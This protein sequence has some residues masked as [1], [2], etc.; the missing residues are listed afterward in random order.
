MATSNLIKYDVPTS[1][2]D[3]SNFPSQYI[4]RITFYRQLNTVVCVYAFVTKTF[5]N[6]ADH[7]IISQDKIPVDFRPTDNDLYRNIISY[8]GTVRHGLIRIN[9]NGSM[10]V[11]MG[12]ANTSMNVYGSIEYIVED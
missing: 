6:T 9:T 10:Q 8:M 2:M 12:T 1:E 4:P 11:R 5:S 7:T 3:L